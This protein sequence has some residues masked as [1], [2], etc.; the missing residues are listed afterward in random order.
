[1]KK[2]L[3]KCRHIVQVR[4]MN[5]GVLSLEYLSK[6]NAEAVIVNNSAVHVKRMLMLQMVW[7]RITHFFE[8][9]KKN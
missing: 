3:T 9:E 7:S 8:E 2:E 4:V 1:M 6:V 5:F